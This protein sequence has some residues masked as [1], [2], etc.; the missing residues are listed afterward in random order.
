MLSIVIPTLNEE[1]YLLQLLKSIEE[2]D[3]DDYEI[4]VADAN[5]KDNTREIAKQFGAKVVEGG[6]QSVGRNRGVEVA[7][8]DLLLFLDADNMLPDGFF[9]KVLNEFERRKLDVATFA[10]RYYDGGKII[11]FLA[12]Y[13]WNCSGYIFGD[14]ATF[15][16]GTILIRKEIHEKVNGFDEEIKEIGED[17]WYVRQASEHG[18][19]G[20]IHSTKIL[21]SVRRFERDGYIS[22]ILK[23]LLSGIYMTLFGPIKSNL[24]NYPYDHY[25]S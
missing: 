8:G 16:I 19:L 21:D 6:F 4:I 20:F 5:S 7:Q 17:G 1:E 14:R 11:N 9:E 2:Q 3:F 15:V 18:Q 22:T 25:D 24:F 12:H 13:F 10:I 23:R